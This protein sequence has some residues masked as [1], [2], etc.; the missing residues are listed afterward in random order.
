MF[1][2][3]YFLKHYQKIK[4]TTPVSYLDFRLCAGKLHNI[5][6]RPLSNNYGILAHVTDKVADNN[7]P[8]GYNTVAPIALQTFVCTSNNVAVNKTAVIAN[9][10]GRIIIIKPEL[11]DHIFDI[12][13]D[14]PKSEVEMPDYAELYIQLDEEMQ[15]YWEIN[16]SKGEGFKVT[17]KGFLI[18]SPEGAI[19]R[20]LKIDT[21]NESING[22]GVFVEFFSKETPESSD[23]NFAVYQ[24]DDNS[25][26]IIDEMPFVAVR[27]MDRYFAIQAHAEAILKDKTLILTADKLNEPAKYIWYNSEEKEIGSGNEIEIELPQTSGWYKLEVI[28]EMDYYK[29]YDNVYVNIPAGYIVSLSPNPTSNEVRVEYFLSELVQ[30]AILQIY[31]SSGNP[32]TTQALNITETE[33]RISLSGLINGTYTVVLLTNGTFADSKI[34]IK[35]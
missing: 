30:N 16:G 19:I 21:G 29:D 34:L 11:K 35:Q 15:K 17:D 12:V 28:A 22:Y 18:T 23:F 8:Y 7:I 2:T 3:A 1:I 20:N 26:E 24:I 13:V 9:K 5:V 31:N 6:E 4:W 27:N 25:K 14:F 10:S 32:V 33:S